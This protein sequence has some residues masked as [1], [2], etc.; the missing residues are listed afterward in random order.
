MGGSVLEAALKGFVVR[1]LGVLV[2]FGGIWL[3]A[4]EPLWRQVQES[5]RLS[6]TEWG[7]MPDIDGEVAV[8]RLNGSLL[9]Q[10]KAA[11]LRL[12]DGTTGALHPPEIRNHGNGTLSYSAKL[13][14]GT[15]GVQL[16][17]NAQ[18]RV[19]G[20]V[21][22]GFRSATIVPLASGQHIMMTAASDAFPACDGGVSVGQNLRNI[23]EPAQGVT[24]I[25]VMVVATQT[26]VDVPTDVQALAQLAVNVTNDAYTRSGVLI[27]LNLVHTMIV[28]YP[29]PSSSGDALSQLTN[30]SDGILDEIHAVRDT[31]GADLV[32]FWLNGLN[33]SC[34]R[35]YI[36]GQYA[37]AFGF[38]VVAGFCTVANL[39]FAHEVGH[40]LGGSHDRDNTSFPGL[41]DYSYGYRN[42]GN[43]S[44]IMA[45]NI[46]CDCPRVAHFS[47]PDVT[48]EGMTTGIAATDP[49]GAH[50]AQAFN[51]TRADMARFRTAQCVG[52]TIE[53][54]P[55]GAEL[56]E[57][58]SVTLSVTASGTS[59]SYQW[60]RN[61]VL[62]EGQTAATIT[63][64]G[65]QD[66][67]TY[68]CVVS[69]GCG[70]GQT[71]DAVVSVYSLSAD[72][73][74]WPNTTI[75]TLITRINEGC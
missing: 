40:N 51:M 6:K 41:F 49:M 59:V 25:D 7:S 68:Y 16:V 18:G 57:G 70:N 47:N 54:Q 31:Y 10:P 5:A 34:G 36:V 27:Q 8:I 46:E 58:G 21:A 35:G 37:P 9:R 14:D 11:L 50:N 42:Q 63:I 2:A 32:S 62:L 74:L 66:V 38:N 39:S 24:E 3:G 23:G 67:G 53:T 30:T 64:N 75:F 56:C 1:L 55:L 48:Y 44:T 65:T 20:Y 22:D 33:G 52:P 19:Y 45:Y 4:A 15:G 71:S 61:E 43:F 13:V 17:V 72:M 69:N 26:L 12:A 73:A 60:Y 29:D 28:D